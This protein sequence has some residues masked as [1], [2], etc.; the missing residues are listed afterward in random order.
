M[1]LRGSLLGMVPLLLLG[2]T[3]TGLVA[4]NA[5][6]DTLAGDGGLL[7]WFSCGNTT[8]GPT[9]L[10]LISTGASS[11][12][13]IFSLPSLLAKRSGTLVSVGGTTLVG[14]LSARMIGGSPLRV[15]PK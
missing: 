10:V 14:L 6:G 2:R 1:T 3:T 13:T 8:R 4:D 12:G 11:R 5:P 7:F 15:D 9:A